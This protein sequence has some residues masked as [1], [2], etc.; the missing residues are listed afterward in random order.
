MPTI[1]L[2]KLLNLL[3]SKAL[4]KRYRLAGY[5]KHTGGR[6]GPVWQIKDVE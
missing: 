4:V 6:E 2:L 1:V 3:G 5:G